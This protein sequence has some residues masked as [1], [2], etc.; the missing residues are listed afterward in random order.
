MH[1]RDFRGRGGGKTSRPPDTSKYILDGHVRYYDLHTMFITE[2]LTHGPPGRIKPGYGC[3]I[4]PLIGL[5][6]R[7]ILVNEK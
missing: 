5:G 2:C 6:P 7:I 3:R 4:G 1:I